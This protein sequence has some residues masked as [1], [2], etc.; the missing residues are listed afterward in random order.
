MNHREQ[1][2]FGDGVTVITPADFAVLRM[3]TGQR[4]PTSVDQDTLVRL[5]AEGF[6]VADQIG[7]VQPTEL[8]VRAVSSMKDITP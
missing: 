5:V 8:A 1:G 6:L 2:E 7:A 3:A 4:E